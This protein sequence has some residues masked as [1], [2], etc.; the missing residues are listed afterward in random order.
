MAAYNIGVAI[1][2]NRSSKKT[3]EGE[4]IKY[5]DTDLAAK[6]NP[7]KLAQPVPLAQGP[8]VAVDSPIQPESS[9]AQKQYATVA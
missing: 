5:H 2:L 9:Q 6:S 3:N 7:V 1:Y 8:K 4:K